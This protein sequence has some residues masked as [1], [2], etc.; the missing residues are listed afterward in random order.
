MHR[1]LTFNEDLLGINCN[2]AYASMTVVTKGK[3]PP[4]L[5]WVQH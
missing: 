5:H 1:G 3:F 4:V 2:I